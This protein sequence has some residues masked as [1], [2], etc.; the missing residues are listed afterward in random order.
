MSGETISWLGRVG[1]WLGEKIMTVVLPAFAAT[2]VSVFWWG[3]AQDQAVKRHDAVLEAHEKRFE[4]LEH[5]ISVDFQ[6]IYDEMK[7]T[8]KEL[9]EIKGEL[10]RI[11]K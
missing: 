2:V 8:N 10:R 6:K 9:G 5:Q 3:I 1:L 4:K 11:P 7:V